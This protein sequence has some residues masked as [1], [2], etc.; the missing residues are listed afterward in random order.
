M[1][2]APYETAAILMDRDLTPAPSATAP[3]GA[4]D[5]RAVMRWTT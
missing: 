5:W 2:D 1:D 3:E 4:E